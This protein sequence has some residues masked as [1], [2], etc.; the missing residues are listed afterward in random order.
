VQWRAR[1]E[2][3]KTEMKKIK[4]ETQRVQWATPTLTFQ[5]SVGEILQQGGGKLSLQ[6]ADS[7]EMRCEKPHVDRCSGF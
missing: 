4:S 3:G 5:G 1:A 7:G 6:L 2:E